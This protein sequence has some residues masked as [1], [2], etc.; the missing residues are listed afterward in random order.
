MIDHCEVDGL[1]DPDPLQKLYLAD[2]GAQFDLDMILSQSRFKPSYPIF[3]AAGQH[4]DE[5]LLGPP[6]DLGGASSIQD[7]RP[8]ISHASSIA[9][10]GPGLEAHAGTVPGV[11]ATLGPACVVRTNVVSHQGWTQRQTVP[12]SENS[13]SP[14]PRGRKSRKRK[15]KS[16]SG[17]GRNAKASSNTL[18]YRASC[19]YPGC[20]NV[21]WSKDRKK[22]GDNLY[23]HHQKKFHPEWAKES[24]ALKRKRYELSDPYPESIFHMG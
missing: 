11:L 20:S 1:L 16:I 15:G 2:D 5:G 12:M 3:D 14:L 13:N 21:M 9:G 23:Q 22:A 18:L 10:L 8:E 4:T 19:L 6:L 24:T 17:H 7:I